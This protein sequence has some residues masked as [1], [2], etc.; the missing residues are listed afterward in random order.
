MSTTAVGLVTGAWRR[1][2]AVRL[3]DGRT[4]TCVL[5]GRSLGV[6]CGDR[7]RFDLTADGAGAITAIEPRGT[8]LFRS[9]AYRQKLLAANVTQVLGIVAPV[10][11]YDDELVQRWIIAAESNACRFALI[12]NKRDLPGFA[13]LEPR[14]AACR[15]LGY[16]VV[17]L[18]AQGGPIDLAPVR[19]LVAGQRSLLVG[20][21]GMGKSTLIN[22]LIP[23]AQARVGEVSEALGAGRHTTSET[24][25]YTLDAQSWMIDSPG[26]KEFGLAHL[27]A[28]AIAQGFVDLRP[29]VGHCRFRDCR[30]DVEPGCAVRD[31][32]ARGAVK[33]WR[34]ALLHRLLAEREGPPRA[35]SR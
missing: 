14:L 10:P 19:D 30:H 15:E 32:V 18:H 27:S 25:L 28:A 24:T 22:A 21:S 35:R 31:A 2:F 4:I 20:Q 17:P 13:A 26:M 33:P 1:H 9:D 16:P 5:R 29:F 7:V 11:P 34:L 3:D 6:A 23:G 12:A 8:V